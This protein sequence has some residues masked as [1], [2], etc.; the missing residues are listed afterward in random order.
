[1]KLIAK[2][3]LL[4]LVLVIVAMVSALTAMQ[5]AIHTREVSVPNLVGKSVADAQ[6]AAVAGGLEFQVERQYYSPDVPEGK[7]MSQV[8][9]PGTKVRRGWQL[10]VAQSLGPQRVAIPD[11]SGETSRAAQLNIER[12]GLELGS[13]AAIPTTSA[14][15][16]QVIAQSPPANASGVAAPRISL[17][18]SA[19][20]APGAYVMPNLVGQTLQS[21]TQILQSAGMRL[22]TVKVTAAGATPDTTQASATTPPGAAPAPTSL[23]LSQDPAAGQ[24]IIAGSAVNFEVTR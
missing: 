5:F 13:T 9:D 22:G 11:L 16:D 24:K 7:I 17:L 18:L 3:V 15:P 12:R 23:I 2:L 6:R 8:P 21:A 1:V 10:R 19:A 14:P 20:L 4:G